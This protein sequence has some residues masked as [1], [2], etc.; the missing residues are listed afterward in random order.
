MFPSCRL[1]FTAWVDA[2][3]FVFSL[4][5]ESSFKAIYNYYTQM[6][7]FRNSAEIPLILV[8]TQANYATEVGQNRINEPGGYFGDYSSSAARPNTRLLRQNQQATV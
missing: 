8:G 7:H 1:Q 5:N 4:E 3:I 6:A 2:V